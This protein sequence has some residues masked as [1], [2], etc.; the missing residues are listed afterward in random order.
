MTRLENNERVVFGRSG[1]LWVAVDGFGSFW[2][3][4]GRCGSL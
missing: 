2:V 1:L 4:L 3:I